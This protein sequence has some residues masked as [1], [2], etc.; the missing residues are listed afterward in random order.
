[1]DRIAAPYEQVDLNTLAD[2]AISGVKVVE[3]KVYGP[4]YPRLVKRYT[5]RFEAD[6]LGEEPP[7]G[8]EEWEWSKIKDYLEKN[9][10][11]YPYGFVALPY[12]M[13]KTEAVL[14]GTTGVANRIS[15][16][17]IAKSL[18]IQLGKDQQTEITDFANC[19]K[20]SVDKLVALKVMPPST[21]YSIEDENTFKLV[22][23][24]CFFKDVCEAFM[25]EKVRKYDGSTVCSIARMITTYIELELGPGH[26]Y[27]LD[28]FA[29][30][31]CT[32][33]IIK[34]D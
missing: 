34:T 14:Q 7:E 9:L 5:M 17:E 24:N 20:E 2:I 29:N 22:V 25:K 19:F 32:A 8:S 11:S 33:R 31:N 26:D 15:I 28:E 27:I 12:A 3:T 21:S 6:K 16:N 10:E 23:D 13:A 4:V 1:M 18:N 30:P